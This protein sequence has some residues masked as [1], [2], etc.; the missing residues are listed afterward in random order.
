[1]FKK[2]N[3]LNYLEILNYFPFELFEHF[4]PWTK[5]PSS[6]NFRLTFPEK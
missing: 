4:S 2:F 1:M 5:K 3:C 6:N